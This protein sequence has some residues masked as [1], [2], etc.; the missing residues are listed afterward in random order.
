MTRPLDSA[1]SP[2]LAPGPDPEYRAFPDEARRNLMQ[3][4]LEVPAMIRMLALPT[5]GRILEVGCGR[6]I[7]L[8]ALARALGPSRLMGI[9]IDSELLALAGARLTATGV[10]AELRRADVR[11]LPFPDGSFDLVIDFGTCYHIAR[12]A[13]AL[14]EIG[15]VLAPGGVFVEET[16]VSQLLSHPIRALGRRLPWSEARHLAPR[17]WGLLWLSRVRC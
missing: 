6:G 14:A 17:R 16:P 7:A 12:A 1:L 2:I 13:L 10:A 9:D 15:R 8:P 4:T 5:G 3:E 11:S